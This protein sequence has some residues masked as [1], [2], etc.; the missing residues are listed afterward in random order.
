M[1]ISENMD[2]LVIETWQAVLPFFSEASH[3]CFILQKVHMQFYPWVT[4]KD[5]W[6]SSCF[7]Y[8]F[9]VLQPQCVTL[10]GTG[11]LEIVETTQQTKESV[12]KAT[13]SKCCPGML[14]LTYLWG[15]VWAPAVLVTVQSSQQNILISIHL[16][17]PQRLLGVITDHKMAED[18]LLCLRA[19]VLKGKGDESQQES[20]SGA[21][22]LAA[23]CPVVTV[24]TQK[25]KI[26]TLGFDL[27]AISAKSSFWVD[28]M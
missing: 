18:K 12:H 13:I 19:L 4:F 22:H 11:A 8:L 6:L 24:T 2:H 20:M 9:A 1:Y 27:I 21:G 25:C 17:K 23:A 10:E 26:S 7:V 15:L 3:N 16:A 14:F 28:K 5:F